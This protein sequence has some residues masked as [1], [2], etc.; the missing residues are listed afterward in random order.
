[1]TKKEI[2]INSIK[3]KKEIYINYIGDKESAPGWRII[4]PCAYGLTL[5]SNPAIRAFQVSF[6]SV[7]KKV[8]Y[9]RLFRLD[10]IKAISFYPINKSFA[11]ANSFNTPEGYVKGDK[12]LRI[13]YEQI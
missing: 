1:M 3:F 12:Q 9:W 13:I 5:A 10:R 6:R 11:T 4:R 8:P 7:S 2:I